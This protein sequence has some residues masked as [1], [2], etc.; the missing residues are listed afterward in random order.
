VDAILY[1]LLI[2]WVWVMLR[3]Q[4]SSSSHAEPARPAAAGEPAL[5]EGHD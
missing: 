5:A 4:D 2:G 1:V 3:R